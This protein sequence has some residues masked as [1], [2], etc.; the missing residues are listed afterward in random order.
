MD[1]S[2]LL[3]AESVPVPLDTGNVEEAVR[4]LRAPGAP[5]EPGPSGGEGERAS[6]SLHPAGPDVVLALHRGAAAPRLRIGVASEPLSSDAPDGTGGA[7]LVVLLETP[8]GS[9]RGEDPPRDLVAALE[10][11]AVRASIRAATDVSELRAIRRFASAPVHEPVRVADAL[12]PMAYRIYPDTPVPEVLD[13]MAR[14]GLSAVPVVG[15]GMQVVGILTSGD[16]IRLHLDRNTRGD[17]VLT[18]DVMTRAVLCVTEDQALEDAAR[19]MVN[20]NLRQL[21]VVREGELVGFLTREAALR[22]LTSGSSSSS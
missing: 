12:Q 1:I 6:P 18:R 13:L 22:G 15:E 5:G 3:S 14:K 9:P 16:A 7:T 20:R 21:P 4:R 11:P 17:D 8:P 10:D 19:M 2:A